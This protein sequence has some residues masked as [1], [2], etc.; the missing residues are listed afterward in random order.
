MESELL[1]LALFFLKFFG[2]D[3]L[4][5]SLFILNLQGW[6]IRMHVNLFILMQPF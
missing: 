3:L 5:G 1:L 2:C 4:F 6:L